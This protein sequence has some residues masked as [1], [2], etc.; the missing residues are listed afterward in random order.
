MCLQLIVVNLQT[1]STLNS[2]LLQL[3]FGWSVASLAIYLGKLFN[4]FNK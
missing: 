1:E 3:A 4:I 2:L